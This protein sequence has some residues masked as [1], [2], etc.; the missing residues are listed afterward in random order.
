VRGRLRQRETRV[1]VS[2]S[3]PLTSLDSGAMETSLLKQWTSPFILTH[4]TT[5]QLNIYSHDPHAYISAHTYTQFKILQLDEEMKF[6][7]TIVFIAVIIHQS[8]YTLNCC[9]HKVRKP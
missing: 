1:Q 2:Q 8:L 9:D 6:R 3:P 5:S 7:T 4:T